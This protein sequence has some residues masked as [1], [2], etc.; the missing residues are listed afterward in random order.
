[1]RIVTIL[2]CAFILVFTGCATTKPLAPT[3]APQPPL[4]F[5]IA[6]F[7]SAG[8]MV[9]FPILL[10]PA[11]MKDSLFQIYAASYV[12]EDTTW[13]LMAGGDYRVETNKIFPQL[14]GWINLP[15]REGVEWY[16]VRIWAEMKSGKRM[17]V[18]PLNIYAREDS[19]GKFGY[20]F[21]FNRITKEYYPV[22][23][24]E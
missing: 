17:I 5:R 23:K 11:I 24:R 13:V 16:S 20:E 8:V 15:V 4:S 22:P 19:F 9:S 21:V 1:M 18:S 3:S 6:G 14:Y 10:A 2:V 12:L 7:D